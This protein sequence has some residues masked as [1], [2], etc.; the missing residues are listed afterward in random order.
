MTCVFLRILSTMIYE[1]RTIRLI[2][3]RSISSPLLIK[4]RQCLLKYLHTKMSHRGVLLLK[5]GIETRN[6]NIH[7]QLSFHEKNVD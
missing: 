1:K 6:T 3:V 7:K 4:K 2:N 5:T